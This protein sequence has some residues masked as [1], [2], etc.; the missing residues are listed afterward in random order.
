LL[1][2]REEEMLSDSI[3]F[4]G[5]T[6]TQFQLLGL[7]ALLLGVAAF[8][9]AFARERKTSLKRSDVTNELIIEMSRI[10]QALERIADQGASQMMRRAAQDAARASTAASAAKEAE[11]AQQPL[12]APRRIAYSMFGR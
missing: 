9:M 11:A 2:S 6:I 5:H 7:G 1:P 4:A 10:A 8:L 3:T 12:P